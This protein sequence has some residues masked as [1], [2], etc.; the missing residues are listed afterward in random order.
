MA[1]G[2]DSRHRAC[3]SLSS[4]ALWPGPISWESVLCGCCREVQPSSRAVGV[5]ADTAGAHDVGWIL[6]MQVA[7]APCLDTDLLKVGGQGPGAAE[8][9]RGVEPHRRGWE[10]EPR[11]SSRGPSSGRGALG[12]VCRGHGGGSLLEFST[13]RPVGAD[14]PASCVSAGFACLS[15]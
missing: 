14:K 6:P 2:T 10:C 15:L 5:S 4:A 1:K 3:V 12:P 9:G 7:S 8:L 11:E 13:P